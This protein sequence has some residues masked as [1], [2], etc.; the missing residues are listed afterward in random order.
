MQNLFKCSC[1]EDIYENLKTF[2][3]HPGT[4]LVRG[5]EIVEINNY[6]LANPLKSDMRVLDLGCA[7]GNIGSMVFN[8]I[9]V[10]LDMYFNELKEARK[11]LV[12]QEFALADARNMPF[13]DE[14]FDVIFSNSVIEH[15]NDLDCVLIEV[16]RSL[17]NNG[18][19]IFTVPTSEFSHNLY[20]TRIFEKIGCALLGKMYAKIRN[21]Q[22][23]HFNLFND[24]EW[25][26]KLNKFS[27][28]TIYKKHYLSRAEVYE[29]DKICI[30]LRIAKPFKLLYKNLIGR[31]YGKTISLLS[32]R[33]TSDTGS[34][35]FMV[36][37]KRRK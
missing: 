14:S 17:S 30:F 23:N 1:K 34:C 36:A 37:Q 13:K 11:H 25:S 15:I 3:A 8:K 6:C 26:E 5:R 22:L 24:L 27:L 29:W 33:H 28:N 32:N 31:F 12:Y 9:D 21:K 7:E 20:I 19:F 10:G 4:L 2:F 18:L 35:V 16:S